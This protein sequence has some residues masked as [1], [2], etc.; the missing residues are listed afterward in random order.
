[1]KNFLWVEKYRPTTISDT[2]L[3]ASLK[4]TFMNMIEA[5]E[6]QNMLFTGTAGLGKTTVAKALCKQLNL[7]YIVING[8]EEGN[9][10]TLRGK[11]KQF[12]STVSLAGGKKVIILDEADYLNPQST[13]PALRGFIEQFSDNCRFIL[14]C[15][16][17]NRIIEPLH[18]RCGIYE[19]NTSKKDTAVLAGQFMTRLEQILNAEQVTYNKS[20]LAE[21]IMKHVPDWRRVINECQRCNINGK[22]DES[23]INIG[24]DSQ[25][26]ELL[27]HLKDKNFKK[28]RSWVVNNIDV[29]AAA[30]FRGIY[31][32][33]IDTVQ[34][35]SI[36]Q[37]VLILADYQYKNA[38]VADHELN[39]VACMTEI[40]SNVE[41]K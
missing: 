25:Y 17:K 41:F 9:I 36:P 29:D 5:G 12:A 26:N 30:I 20:T 21:V 8:S 13:Q 40:M 10:D 7:D 23:I 24:D 35:T 4:T 32:R 15:N 14:T 19:F 33:M 28:M 37:L 11:I 3:P 22:L 18:S 38:F 1:M 31:D 16:F 2:I 27:T 34:P 6:L 39:I